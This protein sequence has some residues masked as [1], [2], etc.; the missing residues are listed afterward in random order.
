MLGVI[1]AG[2]TD[3]PLFFFDVEAFTFITILLL[4]ILFFHRC[5]ATPTT[6]ERPVV[7][8]DLLQL[9]V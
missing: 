4:L 3:L 6:Y 1:P 7:L 8:R 9:D 2:T 5:L